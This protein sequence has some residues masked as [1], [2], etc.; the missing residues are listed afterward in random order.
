MSSI[1]TAFKPAQEVSAWESSAV[2]LK[3]ECWRPL[4]SL[5]MKRASIRRIER[6]VDSEEGI[7]APDFLQSI[8]SKPDCSSQTLI[9]LFL[10]ALELAA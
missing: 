8:A 4:P 7:A 3:S 5:E 2:R 10:L 9:F 1:A 6:E